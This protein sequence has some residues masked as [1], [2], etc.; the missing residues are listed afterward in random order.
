MDTMPK[1]DS[2]VLRAAGVALV[3]LIALLSH[4]IWS[5]VSMQT[6]QTQGEQIL[7][8]VLAVISS[9][10]VVWAMI[11]RVRLPN[12]PLSPSAADAHTAILEKQG[13][14]LSPAGAPADPLAATSGKP[15]TTALGLA[16]A[17]FSACS[18]LAAAGFGVAFVAVV[19]LAGCQ[20][21]AR[22]SIDSK[23]YAANQVVISV[24]IGTDQALN[25]GLITAAQA[26]AVSVVAHQVNPLIDSVRAAEAAN[27]PTAA[28]QTMNLIN[29]L[30][31]GLQ[32]YV[33][34]PTSSAPK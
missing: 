20:L 19:A 9:G 23:L 18:P 3:S 32:A 27:N 1:I 30:L 2:H 28:N 14:Q 6:V 10:G 8:A 24:E 34:A 12:P 22:Q 25:A 7:D 4:M 26:R 21:L 11:A 16:F 29:S 31:A 15:A 5:T 33:P 17:I 13:L